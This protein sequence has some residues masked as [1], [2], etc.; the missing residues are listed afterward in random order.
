LLCGIYFKKV[1][2]APDMC[3]KNHPT[4]ITKNNTSEKPVS[5]LSLD[6]PAMHLLITVSRQESQH[7]AFCVPPAELERRQS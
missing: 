2:Q 7:G 5:D 3:G 1:D 4:N 6:H